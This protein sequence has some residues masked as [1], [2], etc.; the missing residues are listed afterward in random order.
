MDHQ[1]NHGDE[2]LIATLRQ[3]A[4]AKPTKTACVFLGDGEWEQNQHTYGELDERVSA[5][6]SY[7]QKQAAPG[8]RAIL[9]LPPGF[10]FLESF[11]AC[12]YAGIIAVPLFPPR[13]QRYWNRLHSV[14]ADADAS[15]ILTTSGFL[16][17]IHGWSQTADGAIIPPQTKLLAVD[18]I[19]KTTRENDWQ[20]YPAQPAQIALLQYT[21]GSTSAPKG[22]MVSHGNLAEN[23]KILRLVLDLSD[24]SVMV[25]WLPHYHDM[26]LIEG[27]LTPLFVGA[28]VYLMAPAAFLQQPARWLKALTKY[29]ATHTCAANFAFDLCVER[30]TPK[31]LAGLDLRNL[32]TVINGAEPIRNETIERFH[33][34]FSPC[35]FKA[36]AMCPGYGMAESTLLVTD[37]GGPEQK[38]VT[39]WADKEALKEKRFIPADLTV[40]RPLVSSGKAAPG[41]EICIV[42]PE[43][44][45][46]IPP[47]Q[48]GEVLLH[49]ASIAPGYWRAPKI[50]QEIFE[51][52]IPGHGDKCFLR[53]SDLGFLD[54]DGE[55]FICGRIK[56]LI[57]IDG[58]NHYPQDIEASAGK[59][60]P[61]MAPDAGAAIPWLHEGKEHLVLIQE[62]RRNQRR[63]I[64][65]QEIFAAVAKAIS[66]EHGLAL[67]RLVLLRPGA[68]PKTSSGKIQR[69]LCCA[70]LQDGSHDIMAQWPVPQDNEKPLVAP[71]S[72]PSLK[73]WICQQANKIMGFN[74]QIQTNRPLAEYGLSSV[75]AVSLSGALA[76]HL[77]QD[78]PSYL[79]YQYPTVDALCDFLTAHE[80]A[81]QAA[82]VYRGEP[83]AIIGMACRFPEAENTAELWKMLINGQDAISQ[84]P[85]ERWDA[86]FLAENGLNA[87]QWGAF[88]AAPDQFDAAFFG[89]SPRE[90]ASLDPQQRLLLEVSWEALENAGQP[91]RSLQHLATGVFV[92]VSTNDYAGLQQGALNNLD[93]Y[94]ATG[95]SNSLAANRISYFLDLHG[96][97]MAIDTAC[98]SSLVAVHQACRSLQAGESDL[99]LAAGVN[100]LLTP[101]LTVALSKAQMMSP[102]G[103]CKTF[104]K[105]AD[106]Y[107]RGE[108]CGVVVLKRL[109]RAIEEGDRVLAIIRGS[110]V[111]HGGRSNGLTAPTVK[112][113]ETVIRAALK[114]AN[115]TGAAIDF[116][117]AHGT[118]TPLGD[119]IE[120]EALANVLSP[121]RSD[122]EPVWVGSIKTNIG[123]LEAAAGIAG[124]IKSILA[125]QKK[126]LPQQLHFQHINP[127]IR[128]NR[129]LRV[130]DHKISFSHIHRPLLC[131]VSSFG[132][133]GANAHLILEGAPTTE[134]TDSIETKNCQPVMLPISAADKTALTERA[135]A[136]AAFLARPETISFTDL[137]YTLNAKMEHLEHRAA[138]IAAS[139]GEFRRKLEDFAEGRKQPD[140]Q[141]QAANGA[142][143]GVVFVFSGQGT[144]WVGMGKTLTEQSPEFRRSLERLDG[145][146]NSIADWSIFAAFDDEKLSSD[147]GR[148][149]PTLCALQISLANLFK[150]WGLY[151]AAVIGH[152][153]GEIAAACIAGSLSE[154]EAMHVAIARGKVMIAAQN[155]G[156][157]LATSLPAADLQKMIATIGGGLELAADNSL[158]SSVAS[159][160]NPALEKL[161]TAI[162][163]EG[164]KAFRLAGNTAFHHDT[165]TPLQP[166]LRD[167]LVSLKP[168]PPLLP[169]ASTALGQLSPKTTFDADYWALNIRHPVLF[170]TALASLIA[171]GYRHFVEIGP[172]PALTRHIA[173][174]L[175]AQSRKGILSAMRRDGA[176]LSSILRVLAALFADGLIKK[177]N[178]SKGGSHA[179]LTLPA[180]PW[181]RQR[182]WLTTSRPQALPQPE[183]EKI[184]QECTKAGTRQ[185]AFIPLDLSLSDYGAKWDAFNRLALADMELTLRGLN[186]DGTSFP[187]PATA[188]GATEERFHG[189]IQRWYQVLT[190]AHRIE[191]KNGAYQL[192][193]S[194][195]LPKRSA[196]I[197][198]A[199]EVSADIGF[200]TDYLIRCGDRLQE[201][202]Q[203][204]AEALETLFPNGS[205]Q[206]AQNLYH[207]WSVPRYFNAIAA[208][209][210]QSLTSWRNLSAPLRILEVGGGTGGT[211]RALLPTLSG[212]RVEYTYTDISPYFI[213]PLR[214]QLTDFPFV[215]FGIFDLDQEPVP[216][217]YQEN[218]YDVIV[219]ANSVHTVKNLPNTLRNLR[220]L[221]APGGIIILYEVT[222]PLPWFD[223]SVALIEGWGNFKDDLRAGTPLLSP[224]QWQ[225]MLAE[226]GF[227]QC[228]SFPAAASPAD[229]LAQH[230]IVAR[231]AVAQ[232]DRHGLDEK[233]SVPQ[234]WLYQLGWQIHQLTDEPQT[235]PRG[236]ILIMGGQYGVA[237]ALQQKIESTGSTAI[238]ARNGVSSLQISQVDHIIHLCNLDIA[239]MDLTEAFQHGLYTA[240]K[241]LKTV[242]SLPEGQRP[243]LWFATSGAC[244]V[245]HEAVDP[246]QA[247]IWGWARS[248]AGE[249]PELMGGIVDLDPAATPE[250][251]AE[252]LVA[253]MRA[254]KR[255]QAALRHGQRYVC[256]LVK[257]SPFTASKISIKR[258][259]LYLISGGLGVLGQRIAMH[260]AQKK[261]G[262]LILLSRRADRKNLDETR[263]QTI[264][265][266]EAM[267]TAVYLVAVDITNEDDV[268]TA[269][270]QIESQTG[271]YIV[272]VVHAAGALNT[273]PLRSLDS[274]GFNTALHAKAHGAWV[275]HR[276]FNDRA[277][278]FFT[279]FGSAASILP[280]PSNGAYAAANAF[281]DCLAV[282]RR[283][284]NLAATTLSWGSWEQAGAKAQKT[285]ETLKR[286]S[287]AQI[288]FAAGLSIFADLAAHDLPHWV[289]LPGDIETWVQISS[290]WMGFPLMQGLAKSR[291]ASAT[292]E[293]NAAI[294]ASE[295]EKILCSEA[296]NLMNLQPEKLDKHRPLLEQ[297]LDSLM[298]IGLK[299]RIEKI[300]GIDV[301]VSTLFEAKNLTDLTILINREKGK[302][303]PSTPIHDHNHGREIINL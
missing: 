276:L 224:S 106:G 288:P 45:Q 257:R 111:N 258:E 241:L 140:A 47:G 222:K 302:E 138:F 25:S 215:S 134:T 10:D 127:D 54:K 130:A 279:M 206:T 149:Q 228:Q 132:F 194:Q 299:G 253:E 8:Q 217:G 297:G 157:L 98:S 202:L 3:H 43:T 178:V 139:V 41:I 28:T 219:G 291:P 148:L 96:P 91:P 14:L 57:I 21:S 214:R 261:A 104:D 120:M 151:P 123:H 269:L 97:S 88:L 49:G 290:A 287:L 227:D 295:T 71:L 78:L 137:A 250:E 113:Q 131:G 186:T 197:A 99:A 56:D 165:M 110:S 286:L 55:L 84:V 187:D 15:L 121:N 83:V 136:L 81:D 160:P 16:T 33:E 85:K 103:R 161:R 44:G 114:N 68:I 155:S 61:A 263:R 195:A 122:R 169:I 211:T 95:N 133:G 42:S 203:G 243:K 13:N 59:A 158:Q 267:G 19:E 179:L 119:P 212:H 285:V 242:A 183:S 259:G 303:A 150:H 213:E 53:T 256:R 273:E 275:L 7:L 32:R 12:L 108:G 266:I 210:L 94:H 220:S 234:Q 282:H 280:P 101:D 260:L 128:E 180:Y 189:L 6:A 292:A 129:L 246:R 265:A 65:P 141:G 76:T 35:G 52:K 182:H 116:I 73:V 301:P 63:N 225:T 118:G 66:E 190:D 9:L 199:R 125:L 87:S 207:D 72:A 271:Q 146:I 50:S 109:D 105:A 229:L 200:L 51:T 143:S 218:S 86:S 270:K 236:P 34:V 274:K 198:Q 294:P 39:V 239:G 27:H 107:V 240:Q 152:S 74:Q 191:K 162:L 173:T 164:E 30:I 216:Q 38:P 22:V 221:L 233:K 100:M 177:V 5:L 163:E 289:V 80:T 232:D 264:Q 58:A 251:Q 252:Q 209:I 20:P 4:L 298:I 67:H 167:A 245:A 11:L 124:L 60:H 69:S 238:Q 145:Y 230:I 204:R 172:H 277:L 90:A 79:L 223:T 2:L 247:P 40:G 126:V 170:K 112:A 278:D 281:L 193:G 284:Q 226:N 75:N 142:A 48:I 205:W 237:T 296:A 153:L 235:N 156:G 244:Q 29:K 300:F 31:D 144:Q 171:Q 46:P 64:D 135:G 92:G 201:I 18:E 77:G 249:F 208:E 231:A 154:E 196:L 283:Q 93:A 181:Q 26:G 147:P 166:L 115:I 175:T 82:T 192:V 174:A 255:T 23:L 254:G 37:S 293:E 24:N 272:G 168:S 248:A 17:K 185:A 188:E 36:T 102:T 176:D 89:I 268:S 159:G 1:E 262:G 70:K 117:E 62:V 184:W